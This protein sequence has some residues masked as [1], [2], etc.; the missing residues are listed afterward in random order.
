MTKQNKLKLRQSTK[1]FLS[2]L[3]FIS[4]CF[5]SASYFFGREDGTLPILYGGFPYVV[6]PYL[7]TSL[8]F[9][10]LYPVESWKKPFAIISTTL[11]GSIIAILLV[12]ST[13]FLPGSKN[14]EYVMNNICTPALRKYY[15]VNDLSKMPPRSIDTG[16]NG[17][18][19]WFAQ[20]LECED[21][22]Y[23]GKGPVFSESPQGF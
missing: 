5:F 6:I 10:L 3:I 21:N 18:T 12:I 20:H 2:A 14:H 22:F 13:W 15:N 11:L 7:I 23:K 17:L 4:L 9:W 19:R 8:V 1:L 16:K